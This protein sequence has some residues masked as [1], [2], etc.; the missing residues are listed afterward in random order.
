MTIEERMKLYNDF[1]DGIRMSMDKIEKISR[2]K[3]TWTLNEMGAV[4][5]MMKD[6]AITEKSIAKAH[7]IYSEH[8]IETY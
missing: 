3:S 6:L 2:E 4:I 8:H 1:E 7:K 5:D